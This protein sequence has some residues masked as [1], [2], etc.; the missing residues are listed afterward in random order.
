MSRRKIQPRSHSVIARRYRSG[1]SSIRIAEDYRVT[2]RAILNLLRRLGVRIKG[3]GRY[4][5]AA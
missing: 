2:P 1:E 4:R 5:S 3:R